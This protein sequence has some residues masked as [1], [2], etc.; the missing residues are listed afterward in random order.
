[1]CKCARYYC[2]TFVEKKHNKGVK[3]KK[4]LHKK[5]A[6]RVSCQVAGTEFMTFS[7]CAQQLCPVVLLK[8]N[9]DQPRE[10][11]ILENCTGCIGSKISKAY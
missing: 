11:N 1:M 4:T 9:T 8:E 10:H 5:H 7:F 6:A 2:L 3:V